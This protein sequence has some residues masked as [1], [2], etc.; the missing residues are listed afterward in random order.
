MK[1]L[2]YFLTKLIVLVCLQLLPIKELKGFERIW[3]NPGDK[4]R[5]EFILNPDHLSLLDQN[6]KRIVEPGTFEV[7]IGSSSKKY[8]L[9]VNLK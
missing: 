9:I 6:L 3:L 1:T 4:K 2:E 5:V 7:M 8:V